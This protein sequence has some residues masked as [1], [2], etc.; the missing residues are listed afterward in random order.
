VHPVGDGGVGRHTLRLR[1]ALVAVQQGDAPDRH[2]WL[3]KV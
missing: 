2:G 1:E 3:T